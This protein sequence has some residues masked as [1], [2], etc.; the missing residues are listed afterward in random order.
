MT[1]YEVI[2]RPIV[3]EK[4]VTKKDAEQTLCFEVAPDANKVLVK[5][6]VEQLFKVKVAGVRTFES[7]GQTAPAR[8]LHRLPVGLEEGLREAEGRR[9]DARVRG[10]I[11]GNQAS[12][13]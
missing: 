6:A 4:G 13:R 3:T 1:I 11:K 7:G 5:A 9:K 12:C 8:A 2:K 10:D